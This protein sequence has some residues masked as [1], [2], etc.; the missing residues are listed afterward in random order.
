MHTHMSPS[1]P[2]ACQGLQHMGRQ[3]GKH[4][5]LQVCLPL[6]IY[7]LCKIGAEVAEHSRVADNVR[8]DQICSHKPAPSQWL[9]KCV[10]ESSSM[11][12]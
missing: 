9:G 8:N 7:K 4:T 1:L 10:T 6:H 3:D 11:E 5:D 2:Q 12:S